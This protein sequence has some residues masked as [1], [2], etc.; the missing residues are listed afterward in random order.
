MHNETEPPRHPLALSRATL[1]LALVVGGCGGC[2]WWASHRGIT[3]AKFERSIR[4]ELQPGCS[5]KEVED[6][7]NRHEIEPLWSEEIRVTQIGDNSVAELAGFR[8]ADLS[9]MCFGVVEGRDVNVSLVFHG[10]ISIYFFFDARGR[11]VGHYIH[12]F[13]FEL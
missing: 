5:R 1:L 2:Y 12:E 11:C 10:E 3:A 7:F 4:A 9:G 8:D 6:W 13:A